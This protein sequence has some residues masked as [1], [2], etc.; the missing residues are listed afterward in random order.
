M[1]DFDPSKL[2]KKEL[3]DLYRELEKIGTLTS[4]VVD[5]ERSIRD[6]ILDQTK[7]LKFQQTLK[8]DILRATNKLYDIQ[9]N[10]RNEYNR[11]LGTRKA[12]LALDKELYQ[13]DKSVHSLN[14]DIAY[15]EKQKSEYSQDLAKSLTAQVKK[16]GEYKKVLED[17]KNTSDEIRENVGVKGFQGLSELFEKM[18]GKASQLAS[19]F[20]KAAEAA[21][22]TA[23]ENIEGNK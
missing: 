23:Q 21:R 18:G 7:Q 11:E 8:K 19:P 9:Y 15:L 17:Q 5:D 22:E 2:S 6:V 14:Q 20:E 3:Q 13:L 12:T 16:A 1:A 4:N 10:I